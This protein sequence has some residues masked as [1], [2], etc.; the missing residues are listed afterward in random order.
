MRVLQAVTFMLAMDCLYIFAGGTAGFWGVFF[1]GVLFMPLTLA[2]RYFLRVFMFRHGV[3]VKSVLIVGAGRNGETFAQIISS[4]PFTLRR[5][6]AFLDDDPQKQNAVI[7]GVPVL[8]ETADIARIQKDLRADEIVIS[9]GP[10]PEGLAQCLSAEVYMLESPGHMPMNVGIS[11][12]GAVMKTL[13]DYIGALA[14]LVIFS[15]VMIWAA[16]R[17]K[18]EDGGSVLFYHPRIG[19][20]LVPFGV[21]KFRTMQPNAEEVLAEMLKNDENLRAEFAQDFKLR[22]DPRIT[23][24]GHTLRN[25]SIDELPQLFNV[26]RGEMS[27][28]GPRPIVHEEVRDYYGYPLS[29]HVFSVKPGMTGLWQVSGRNDVKDYD[30]RIS[31][32]MD[33][34][35]NWS[36]WLDFAILLR[37][38]LAVISKKGAY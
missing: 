3:L 11:P 36:I 22:D 21:C 14:A 32:D 28:V 18:K 9:D 1:A 31:Y 33:Y 29:R 37:T 27:L 12:A 35:N 20:Y 30:T 34:I 7:S 4:S 38:P 13:I 15:P 16:Y 10:L 17:I 8:G 25:L 23:K 5:A 26:L 2:A 6:A 24:I 19:K